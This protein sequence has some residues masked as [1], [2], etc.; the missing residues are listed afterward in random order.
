M[1]R[2]PSASLADHR[3]LSADSRGN[4]LQLAPF[5]LT[6]VPITC[7]PPILEAVLF[8]RRARPTIGSPHNSRKWETRTDERLSH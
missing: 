7:G 6:L 4:Y 8:L 3:H 1:N 5:S 2:S